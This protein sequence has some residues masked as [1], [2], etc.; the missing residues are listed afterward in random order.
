IYVITLRR[1]TDRQQQ[2]QQELQGLHYKFFF[3]KDKHEFSLTDL[4]QK[5]VYNEAMARNHHRYGKPMQIGQVCVSWSHAEVYRDMLKHNYQRVLIMEDDV[6]I[7]TKA[8]EI[9]PAV[10]QELPPDWELLYL[11][12]AEREKAPKGVFFKQ[13]F[14]HLLRTFKAIRFSHTTINHLYPKKVSEHIYR[15]GYHDCIHA[16]AITQS[17]AEKMLALQQPIS[18]IA[19]NLPAHAA[20]NGLVKGYVV[21]PKL[22]HQQ[23]QVGKSDYSYLNH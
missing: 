1:A 13:A 22:I 8:A 2:V 16:Y 11:G 5:G 12:F 17:A 23:Y 9:F 20:T 4:Q 18:F 7:D 19:D 14:Y 15:A 6:V 10:R 21:L 3:G